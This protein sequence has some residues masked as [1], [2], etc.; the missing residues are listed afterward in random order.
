M[1]RILITFSILVGVVTSFAVLPQQ[2]K[3]SVTIV[4]AEIDPLIIG[5]AAAVVAIGGGAAL[6]LG[7]NG[8][9]PPSVPIKVVTKNVLQ[10]AEPVSPVS[11]PISKLTKA[12][13]SGDAFKSMTWTQTAPR[14]RVSVDPR[15][16]KVSWSGKIFASPVRKSVPRV[17]KI[18]DPEKAARMAKVAA[19]LPSIKRAPATSFPPVAWSGDCF[20]A[21]YRAS[22]IP[23]SSSKIRGIFSWIKARANI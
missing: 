16:S 3:K 10:V 7:G 17:A 21:K 22:V 1:R 15:G 12:A 8:D 18:D 23:V 13:W 6:F 4:K 14:A 5:G 19:V 9:S 20:E 11:T 2:T